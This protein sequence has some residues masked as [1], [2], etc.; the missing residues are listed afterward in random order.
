MEKITIISDFLGSDEP[1][2]C[3]YE[4]DPIDLNVSTPLELENI[5]DQSRNFV[6]GSSFEDLLMNVTNGINGEKL[7]DQNYWVV[8][9]KKDGVEKIHPKS[10]EWF[11]WFN[12]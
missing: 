4:I 3:L 2:Y 10:L 11:E 5:Q 9:V 6:L 12:K 8:T 7:S 1:T